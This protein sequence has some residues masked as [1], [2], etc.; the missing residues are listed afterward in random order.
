MSGDPSGLL[1]GAGAVGRLCP[2]EVLWVK[3]SC[4][5]QCIHLNEWLLSSGLAQ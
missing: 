3:P 2:G 5:N 1:D 4:E